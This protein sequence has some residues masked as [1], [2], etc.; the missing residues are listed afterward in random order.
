MPRKVTRTVEEK[1]EALNKQK[2]DCYHKHKEL[3]NLISLR[4][5]YVR[6]LNS[7]RQ[8]IDHTEEKE[9]PIINKIREINNKINEIKGFKI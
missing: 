9:E 7:A 8:L 4:S 3:Y 1:R 2:R 5:Y 6:R